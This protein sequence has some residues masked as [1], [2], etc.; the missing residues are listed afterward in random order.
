M[1][2][3]PIN[4]VKIKVIPDAMYEAGYVNNGLMMIPAG[5]LFVV[6]CFIWVQRSLAKHL[7]EKE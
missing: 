6:A 7:E 1:K 2:A 5:A 3:M 4:P